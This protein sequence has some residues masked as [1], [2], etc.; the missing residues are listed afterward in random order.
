[1]LLELIMLVLGVAVGYYRG[2][3]DGEDEMYRLCTGADEA[4]RLFYSEISKKTK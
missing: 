2:K 4:R 3:K 1:M